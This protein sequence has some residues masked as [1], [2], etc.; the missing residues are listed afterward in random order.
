MPYR[1]RHGVC[2][3]HGPRCELWADEVEYIDSEVERWADEND[4]D[5]EWVRNVLQDRRERAAVARFASFGAE[6]TQATV[7]GNNMNAAELQLTADG[8][9]RAAAQGRLGCGL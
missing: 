7:D 8:L 3:S 1:R 5:D 2:A 6:E 9:R 4:I